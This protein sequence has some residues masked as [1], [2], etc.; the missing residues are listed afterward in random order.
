MCTSFT[1]GVS[2]MEEPNL[3][4][5]INDMEGQNNNEEERES[6]ESN[7]SLLKRNR[8]LS[9]TSLA[10]VGTKV[11]HIESLDYEINENDLFKHD[12][13]KRSRVQT[14]QCVFIKW[15]LAFLVG[16]LTGG[17]ATLISLSIENISGY[18]LSHLCFSL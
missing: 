11:P 1:S 3:F 16:L 12:W 7:S 15:T 4:A 9:S 14:L 5:T 18:K 17:V 8:T 6:T 10:I 13:R 2:L